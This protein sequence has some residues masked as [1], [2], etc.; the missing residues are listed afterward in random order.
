MQL[1]M[2]TGGILDCRTM[3]VMGEPHE[4]KP[5]VGVGVNEVFYGAPITRGRR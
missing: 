2:R 5:G 1:D 4:N 3:S